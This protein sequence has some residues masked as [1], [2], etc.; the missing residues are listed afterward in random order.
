M[1]E[2][3]VSTLIK[4]ASDVPSIRGSSHVASI[5]YKRRIIS[6]GTNQLKTH[7]IMG[8]FGKNDKSIFL[9]AEI[10]AIVKCINIHGVEILGKCDLYVVRL[11]KGGKVGNSCPCPG[12]QRAIEAFNIRKVYH[13]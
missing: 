13:T 6:V 10:D 2:K 9:H 7:P 5:V 3:I 1:N 12:C 11:T 8:R 4:Y